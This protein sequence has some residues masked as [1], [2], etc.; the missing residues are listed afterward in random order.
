MVRLIKIII[1]VFVLMTV[2]PAVPVAAQSQKQKMIKNLIA[3]VALFQTFMGKAKKGYKIVGDGIHLIRDI[4]NGEFNLHNDYFNSLSSVNPQVKKYAK[5]AAIMQY[6]Y[7]ILQTCEKTLRQIKSSNRYSPGETSYIQKVFDRLLEETSGNMDELALIIKD[8][9]VK[10]S[11]DQ[12]I[13]RID[14]LYLKVQSDRVFAQHFT[15]RT[16]RLGA[17]RSS[18]EQQM[19]QVQTLY[20]D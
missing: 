11:D 20:Q 17:D 12:R 3:Q 8:G 10:M 1:P 6:E 19:Q 16:R 14:K 5:V 7:E 13:K 2:F 15:E 9:E 4:K 18:Y